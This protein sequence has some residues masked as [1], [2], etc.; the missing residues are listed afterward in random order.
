MRRGL[1]LTGAALAA[2]GLLTLAVQ[3]K[4]FA[5]ITGQAA[6]EKA[7]VRL[8]KTAF[9]GEIAILEKNP[10]KRFAIAMRGNG[11]SLAKIVAAAEGNVHVVTATT[12]T[13][14]IT[15]L[16]ALKLIENPEVKRIYLGGQMDPSSS[17]SGYWR[18]NLRTW[19]PTSTPVE[20]WKTS[21]LTGDLG[22]VHRGQSPLQRGYRGK[23]VL[24]GVIEAVMPD[25]RH[26]DFRNAD[27]TTRFVSIW[28]TSEQGKPPA[29]FTYGKDY[30]AAEINRILA[31][32]E[33]Q[34]LVFGGNSEHP[35]N[36]LAAA[37]GNGSGSGENVGC[38]PDATLM[39]V[40]TGYDLVRVIDAA[41]A[42]F[43][44]AD[45]QGMPCVISISMEPDHLLGYAE[46]GTH[47]ASVA[48]S[49]MVEAKPG[50]FIVAATGNQADTSLHADVKVDGPTEKQVLV[51]PFTSKL[52]PNF[53]TTL[54][55]DGP[56]TKDVEFQISSLIGATDGQIPIKS[57]PWMTAA[58]AAEMGPTNF[59]LNE[60]DNAESPGFT[61]TCIPR[62][63]TES[64]VEMA[65]YLTYR[66][67]GR[68][69]GP[70]MLQIKFRGKG[71]AEMWS[72][73][74]AP[75]FG[76]NG[77]YVQAAIPDNIVEPNNRRFIAAPAN[78]RSI[79]AAG[80]YSD[81]GS[82][83]PS[84]YSQPGGMYGG[85]PKPLVLAPTDVVV[86]N[87]LDSPKS[88]DD[89]KHGGLYALYDGTSCS[90]PMLAGGIALYLE[91]HPKATLKEVVAA[92]KASATKDEQTGE[93]PNPQAGYG[94]LNYFR[95][96]QQ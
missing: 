9:P 29:G 46:D 2:S 47:V 54:V 77:F 41:A 64:A 43:Q 38:A 32:D 76:K 12:V 14:D 96:L 35:T 93:V 78:G 8:A 1:I 95:L 59:D 60:T 92:M 10:T 81:S 11:E 33:A 80:A 21:A 94:K 55:C 89:L 40:A 52:T 18:R 4:G 90:A 16:A 44:E 69:D 5:G 91:K 34:F 26:P 48:M 67:P 83:N 57:T 24:V 85:I 68:D 66:N 65:L 19:K 42:I 53:T 72:E 30:D 71:E 23:G 27:G 84:E 45:R 82:S 25:F 37:A 20:Q 22:L 88:D 7:D 31:S 63:N 79:F 73:I 49:E 86:A 3:G 28:N 13:A 51:Y 75:F 61:L 74:Y 17:A 56:N 62:W 15:G 36:S 70:V 6:P 50:R 87:P 58:K 39:Y